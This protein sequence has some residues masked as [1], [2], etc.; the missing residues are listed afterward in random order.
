MPPRQ[1]SA[2]SLGDLLDHSPL[3]YD[4]AWVRYHVKDGEKGPLVWEVK[5]VRVTMKDDAG[6]PGARLR[7]VVARNALDHDE[8]KFFV[9]NAP[10][11]TNM[12]TLLLVAFS[13]WRVER[14]FQDQKQEIGLD[15]W[16]GR[17]YRGLKRHL[18]LSCVSYLFLAR[19]RDRLR[20][21]KSRVDRVPSPRRGGRARAELVA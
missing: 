14:C 15:Q 6:L 10:A 8:V 13:R 21:K 19:V 11:D 4:Q 5:H 3:L 7:L 16:E 17:H 9:S 12:Q 20:G 2:I 18:I 1:V